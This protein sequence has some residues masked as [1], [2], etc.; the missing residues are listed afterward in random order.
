VSVHLAA[1]MFIQQFA[2][3]AGKVVVVVFPL[4]NIQAGLSTSSIVFILYSQLCRTSST[5]F[6]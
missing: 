2:L 5:G 6:L 3:T 1:S 4:W